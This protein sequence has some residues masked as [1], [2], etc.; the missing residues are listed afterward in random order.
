MHL[1]RRTALL[2]VALA[3]SIP[4]AH[5]AL[6]ATSGSG[7]SVSETRSVAAFDSI[8]VGGSIDLVVS[9][10]DKTSLQVQADDNLLPL[11]ITEVES[12]RLKIGW[13]RGENINHRGSVKVTVVTP[14]LTAL[15]AA[16]SG[17]VEL[18]AFNTPALKLSVAGSSNATLS[19]LSTEDL[20]VS[21]AG[22][23]DVRGSG[24]ATKLKVSIAGSG[25]VRLS[26][27]KSDEVG[28][29][30]A[31]SGDAQVNAQKTLNVSI[32]GS[33]DVSYTGDATVKS[34]V[35]GSGS[36]KKR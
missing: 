31:G 21:I 10:G 34:S 7:R 12:G 23:G 3:A 2:A 26:D 11:L 19:T 8:A 9:Q 20:S 28:V 15:S 14:K 5:V 17:K 30:I 25:D 32:A 1:N 24:K 22:S 18:Q 27:L 36:V 13:K 6:A 35:A 29:T 4:A 16:G 33:G